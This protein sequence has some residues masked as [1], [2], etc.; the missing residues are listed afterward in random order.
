MRPLKAKLEVYES[1]FSC[2]LDKDFHTL[3]FCWVSETSAVNFTWW[4]IWSIN[5]RWPFV[6]HLKCF[7]CDN[8]DTE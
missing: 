5:L 4:D 2:G 7:I 1:C 8:D 3:F 6:R